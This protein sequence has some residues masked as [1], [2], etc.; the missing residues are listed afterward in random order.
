M[1]LDMGTGQEDLPERASEERRG[2]SNEK[3]TRSIRAY[4]GPNETKEIHA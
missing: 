2:S 4:N 1:G 3:R